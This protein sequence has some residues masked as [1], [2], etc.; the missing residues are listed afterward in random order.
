MNTE[1]R[2]ILIPVW[3]WFQW[4]FSGQRVIVLGSALLLILLLGRVFGLYGLR[5][6]QDLAGDSSGRS[7]EQIQVGEERLRVETATT[8]EQ[9]TQGLS[10]RAAIGSDGMLFLFPQ[11]STN[12]FWMLRMQFALDIIWLNES[13]IIGIAADVLPPSQTDGVPVVVRPPAP[14]TAVLEVP[15]G[16]A[17]QNDWK[18]GTSWERLSQ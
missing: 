3:N 11:A 18:V 4:F 14:V 10:D 2:S 8:P 7:F 9:I 5:S 13:E 17:A 16:T 12:P 15:A 1:M 6:L